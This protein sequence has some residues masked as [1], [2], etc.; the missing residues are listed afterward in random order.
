MCG[1][2]EA[3]AAKEAKVEA[4]S[5]TKRTHLRSA[6]RGNPKSEPRAKAVRPN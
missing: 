1:S 4:Y 6:G 5:D 2:S 3:R